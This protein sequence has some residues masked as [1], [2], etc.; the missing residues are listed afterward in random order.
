MGRVVGML[1]LPKNSSLADANATWPGVLQLLG[2]Q[3]TL[4]RPLRS[5][6]DADAAAR[7]GLPVEA[8]LFFFAMI[9]LPQI[10]EAIEGIVRTTRAALKRDSGRRLPP[11]ASAA[12]LKIA[13]IVAS[14]TRVFGSKED[15]LDWL[16]RPALALANARPIDVLG[17]DD[18]FDAVAT[19]LR[20]ID[21]CVYI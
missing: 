17:H 6:A 12:T 7:E 9:A 15:A 11:R 1:D 8:A 18:G 4:K 3:Q 16:Q 21:H 19:L 14:A 2:G 13:E 5:E 20:Q 10:I